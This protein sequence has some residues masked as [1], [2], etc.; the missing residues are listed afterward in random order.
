MQPATAADNYIKVHV[1]YVD[2]YGNCYLNIT[3]D[4]FESYR[5]GRRFELQVHELRISK[6]VH[7]YVESDPRSNPRIPLMLTLS[8]TGHLELAMAYANASQLCNMQL[9][10]TFI[11]KFM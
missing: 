11:I 1:A 5:Q 6:I 4:E 7:S 2:S 8:S 3:F 10:D 9:N